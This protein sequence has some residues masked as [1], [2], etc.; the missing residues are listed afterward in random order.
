MMGFDR[1]DARLC[2]NFVRMMLR[3]RFLGS[4]LGS[5]WIV[6][7]PALLMGMFCFVFTQIFPSRL[8]GATSTVGYLI[9]LISG[10]GPWLAM[11]E[12]LANATSSVVA[13]GGLV[14]NM[15]FKTELLPIAAS[16][17]AMV[18]LGVS[19]V[20][21]VIVLGIDGQ[22][23]NLAWLSLPLIILLHAAFI[24]GIG[25]FLAASNVF[26]RDVAQILP[27][28]LTLL[29]FLSPIFYAATAFPPLLAKVVTL[30]P[31]YLIANGYRSPIATG[32]VMP[33]HELALLTI[34]AAAALWFG[35]R[36]FRRLKSYFSGRV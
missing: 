7:N 16:A 2:W 31:L 36:Y 35:L 14:K 15:A 10:Y 13:Q 32:Q 5:V 8:P 12:G 17:L 33:L 4:T 34:Y 29:L 22:G 23:P 21:L 28:M 6:L 25:L 24:A 11:S 1:N 30:S 27:Q 3:D 9:W 26:V 20:F 19:F 18:P